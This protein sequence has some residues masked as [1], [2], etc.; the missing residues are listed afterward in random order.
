MMK[1]KFVLTAIVLF[2]FM[3]LSSFAL[4]A[5]KPVDGNNAVTFIIKNFGIDTKGEFKGLKGDIQWNEENPA[6]S[7][8]NVS[9]NAG[10]INTNIESRD[11]ELKDETYFNT[12]K[13]PVISFVSTGITPNNGSY[14]ATG[15]LSLKGVTKTISFPFTATK[16][17]NGYLFSGSFTINR[18]DYGV[19]KSSMVL[20]DD[21][22]I[23]LK[24]QAVQ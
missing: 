6:A 22:D 10:T 14:K 11:K 5:L 7:T 19:G 18:L 13:Y 8:I 23:A 15:S 21:V 3:L 4:L 16:T 1:N 9:V 12:D 2:C 24:V 20:G 17:A